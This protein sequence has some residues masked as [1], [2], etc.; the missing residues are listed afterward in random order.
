[1]NRMTSRVAAGLLVLCLLLLPRPS[2]ASEKGFL[3]KVRSETAAVYLLGSVHFM[4]KDAYPLDPVIEDA[5]RQS[6]ILAVEADI[7]DLSKVSAEQLLEL[8]LYPAGDSIDRHISPETLVRLRQ[9]TDRLG[10]SYILISRQRPW[11]LALTLTSLELARLGFDPAYG[12]DLHFLDRAQGKKVVELE[13]VSQQVDLLSG[14]PDE[15]QE[16]FLRF[17][18]DDMKTLKE[19]SE[20]LLRIWKAGD[21]KGLEELIGLNTPGRGDSPVLR[22]LFYERNER[23]AVRIEEFLRRGQ[24]A[25]IVVGA[26]HLAGKHGLVELLRAKGYKTEQQ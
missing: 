25:F 15:E 21:M 11:V 23:M 2:L 22:R 3:W 18:L 8:A 16:Q 10:L 14:F 4:R 26:G 9:E 5:F 7:N 1:M 12:I 13:S 20:I 19:D 17:T 6:D 24:K